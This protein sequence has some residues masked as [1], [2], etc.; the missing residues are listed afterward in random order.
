MSG[1]TERRFRRVL[2]LGLLLLSA[3][4]PAAFAA[5][6]RTTDR[7]NFRAAP[8]LDARVYRTLDTNTE[9]EILTY[10]PAG[11]SQATVGGTTGYLKSEYLTAP[12]SS[13]RTTARVNLRKTPSLEG[14]VLKLLDSG[15]AVQP[16]STQDGWTEVLWDGRQG[17]IKSEY[18]LADTASAP[19]PAQETA[20]ILPA[21]AALPDP[22]PDPLPETPAS[23]TPTETPAYTTARVNFR[24]TPSLDGA[25]LKLLA[26]GT[27]VQPVSEQDGWTEVLWDGQRGY[28]KSEY[29]T[30]ASPTP[31]APGAV[32][33]IPWTEAEKI[34]TLNRPISVYDVRSGITYTVQSFSH[35][36]H[37]D[38]EPLTTQDTEL[39]KQTF[40]GVWKWDGRPVWVT[41]NGRTMAAAMNGMPHGGGIIDDNGMDGQ[42][43]LHFPG[44]HVHNGNTRYEN[45]LQAVVQEAWNARDR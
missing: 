40:G 31:A 32:E 9:V 21:E 35:G 11:W 6:G 17:Y 42:I 14:T 13:A 12:Q 37:A 38:V 44:S 2:L 8:S 18:L 27:A 41:I 24:K 39:C 1:P 43:C 3:L 28:I 25:V 30:A 15:V 10:D 26:F 16:V 5:S 34:I 19:P 36:Q 7:V 22:L 20:P 29:L 33:L 45:T 4:A 23:E